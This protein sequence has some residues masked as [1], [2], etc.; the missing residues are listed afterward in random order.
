MKRATT[1]LAAA[2]V[3]FAPVAPAHAQFGGPEAT[4]VREGF[5]LPAG[6]VRILVFRPSVAVGEQTLGGMNEPNADW[7]ETAKR[8]LVA[9]LQREQA[10]RGTT[11]VT[12]PDLPGGQGQLV[13]DYT[14]LFRTVAQAA[15]QHKMFPGDRLPTKR[16]EFDWSLGREAAQLKPLGGDYGL[17]FYTYDSYGST[18]RKVA[19]VLAA[20]AG[21][22]LM[23]S[24]RSPPPA[25]WDISRPTRSSGGYGTRWRSRNAS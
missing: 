9:A 13:A 3:A 14:A 1:A 16:K 20:V 2:I 7:T 19:Q 22:G 8:N 6:D 10:A 18:G 24:P 17:F 23:P 5:R 11:L 25:R 12:V 15:F 4:A 21:M